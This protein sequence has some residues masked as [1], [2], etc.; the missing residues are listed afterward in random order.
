MINL[1]FHQTK[2]TKPIKS[3]HPINLPLPE[4]HGGG[5]GGRELFFLVPRKRRKAHDS[6]KPHRTK[7]KKMKDKNPK[8]ANPN[9]PQ[10]TLVF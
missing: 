6:D 10:Q 5:K 9:A 7:D 2:P 4:S 3:V 8:Y 1:K